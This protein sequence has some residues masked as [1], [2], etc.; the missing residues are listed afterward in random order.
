VAAKCGTNVGLVQSD[1]GVLKRAGLVGRGFHFRG[2]W[3]PQKERDLRWNRVSYYWGRGFSS[4]QISRLTG[5]SAATVVNEI[6]SMRDLM[7]PRILEADE[8]R[9]N[10]EPGAVDRGP[11]MSEVYEGQFME[12]FGRSSF[13]VSRDNMAEF[14]RD[15]LL[16]VRESGR[17]PSDEC[18]SRVLRR[19]GLFNVVRN[20]LKGES[21]YDVSPEAARILGL[22]NQ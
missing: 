12:C 13:E 1:V 10:R 6:G 7:D 20:G 3:L 8:A 17:C 19:Y 5:M 11:L 4:P 18:A 14:F 15:D 21:F 22:E 2:N 16:R 9:R